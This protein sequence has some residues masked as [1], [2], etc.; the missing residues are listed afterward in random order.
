MA[1]ENRHYGFTLVEVFIVAVMLAVLAATILPHFLSSNAEVEVSAKYSQETLRSK[2]QLYQAHH[3]GQ[4]PG[5]DLT[6]LLL[7]TYSAGTVDPSDGPLVH[8]PYIESIPVNPFTGSTTVVEIAN[9]PAASSD[10][11]E[12]DGWLYNPVEGHIWLN[13]RD[14]VAE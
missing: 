14:Y 13:H 2:I 9:N 7:T 12:S 6:E 8:G 5:G 11:T 10:V 1:N 3:N 4:A